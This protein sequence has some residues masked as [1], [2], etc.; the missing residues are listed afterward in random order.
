MFKKQ[1][2]SSS[3]FGIVGFHSAVCVKPGISADTSL[4]LFKDLSALLI[5]CTTLWWESWFS[6]VYSVFIFLTG[7]LEYRTK[8]ILYF[9]RISCGRG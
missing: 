6:Q 4:V 2:Y 5:L 7:D 9:K 3:A 8:G 1:C